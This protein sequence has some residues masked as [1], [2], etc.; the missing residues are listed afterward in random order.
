MSRLSTWY[1]YIMYFKLL[2]EGLALFLTKAEKYLL[3]EL[4]K[5]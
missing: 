5:W 1:I 4:I 3:N 2:E